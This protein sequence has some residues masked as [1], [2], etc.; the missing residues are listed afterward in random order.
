MKNKYF[1]LSSIFAIYPIMLS[2]IFTD[3]VIFYL[4]DL[5]YFKKTIS[6]IIDLI[7][8]SP[9]IAVILGLVFGIICLI[10]T[11]FQNIYVWVPL[12]L[13]LLFMM[14]YIYIIL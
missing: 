11:K 10:K 14:S 5:P 7:I 8:N 13:C 3:K 9:Y 4:S 6:V 12:A 1:I 2:I